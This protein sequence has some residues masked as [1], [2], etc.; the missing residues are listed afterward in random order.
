MGLVI[1]EQGI[2]MDPVPA[3]IHVAVAYGIYDLGTHHDELYGKDV[4][5]ILINWEI[6]EE[7]IELERDGQKLNLPRAISKRYNMSLNT[8]ATLRKDLDAW[9]GRAFTAKELEGFDI[10]NVLGAACQIQVVHKASQTTSKVFANVQTIMALGKGMQPPEMENEP[11]WFSFQ[12]GTELP[13][14]TPGWIA[15]I[16][17][18]SQEWLALSDGATVDEESIPAS[19]GEDLSGMPF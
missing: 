8:K 6:P 17:K 10:K 13:E 2:D 3:G 12:E 11:Q 4:H 15:D 7:R 18:S 14:S 16:I 5:K 9:R 19:D 1:K